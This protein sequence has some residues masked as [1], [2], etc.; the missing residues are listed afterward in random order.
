MPSMSGS[1]CYHRAHER[2]S[3]TDH[4]GENGTAEISHREGGAIHGIVEGT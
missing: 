4:T 2:E 3:K 1:A